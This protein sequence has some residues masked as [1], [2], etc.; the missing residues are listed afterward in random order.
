[1]SGPVFVL[2]AQGKPLMPTS[3]A[4][5]RRLLRSGKARLV[6][7]HAFTVIQLSHTVAQP[8][9]RPIVLGVRCWLHTAELV[10][11]SETESVPL[12]LLRIIADLRTD[13]PLRLRRRAGHR[14]R[15]RAR[16]RYRKLR[17][18]GTPFKLR[19]PTLFRSAWAEHH[20]HRT[21]ARGGTQPGR[22][23]VIPRWRAEA[24]ERVIRALCRLAPIS[25][26]TIHEP[27]ALQLHDMSDATPALRRQLLINAYGIADER[28]RLR[29]RCCYCGTTNGPIHVDHLLPRSRGGSDAWANMVLAC[30][31][32]NERKGNRTP[33]EAGMTLLIDADAS[34][35]QPKRAEPYI[36]QTALRLRR[37][38]RSVLPE[39]IW[40]ADF[41]THHPALAAL[42]LL[43]LGDEPGVL[44]QFVA[45]PIGRPRKQIYTARNYP[46]RTPLTSGMVRVRQAVK[47]RVQVNKGL[48]LHVTNGRVRAQVIPARTAT[49]TGQLIKLG[50]LIR[51]T[52]T[53]QMVR[54]IVSAVQSNGRLA[55]LTIEQVER[56]RITWKRLL[57]TPQKGMKSLAQASVVFLKVG[58]R[59]SRLE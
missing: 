28:G 51:A 20:R 39:I 2:D 54:G 21:R 13:L 34:Q 40:L 23:P 36:L 24:I 1:M 8:I 9:L 17:R 16:G 22:G 58:R 26:V 6:P 33:E 30:S 19:R 37:H 5:A 11:V 56:S 55:L 50:T 38:S 12:P 52:R 45:R 29:A 46:L 42:L 31:T 32:C 18:H 57:I 41:N 7:H 15:R 49:P 4:Y 47:R 35:T 14:R 53:D 27:P 59:T 10:L 3:P 25:Q 43:Q 44:P 48:V